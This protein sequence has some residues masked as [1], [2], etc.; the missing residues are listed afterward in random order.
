MYTILLGLFLIVCVL[1]TV[2]ILLQSSKGGGLAGTFGGTSMG[3]V[4]GG[5]GAA[6]FLSKT[7][8]VLAVLFLLLA[9]ALSKFYATG[10]GE[11]QSIV[12]KK[13]QS[14]SAEGF[15]PQSLLRPTASQP[16]VTGDAG[17]SGQPD[18]S[19]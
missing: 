5:R 14:E 17:A 16:A 12:A 4:F 7:T 9:I 8:T 3:T 15:D 19:K 1:M 2:T 18:T 11:G 13:L 6:T 10:T